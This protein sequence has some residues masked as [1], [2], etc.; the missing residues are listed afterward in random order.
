[1]GGE[2]FR[3]T[4]MILKEKLF[5][6][7][8]PYLKWLREQKGLS[9]TTIL[10][11]NRHYKSFVQLDLS[12]EVIDAFL[13]KQKNNSVVRGFMR[14]FLEFL[15]V[16]D[17]FKIPKSSTGKKK[18]RIIRN[19]SREQIRKVREYSYNKSLKDGLIIDLL[20]FGALRL[21]EI[22]TIKVNSF[23]WDTF[24]DDPTK[25]CKLLI[26]GKGKKQREVLINHGTLKKLLDYYLKTKVINVSMNKDDLVGVLSSNN[27]H[28]FKDLYERKIWGIIKRNAEKS[29]GIAM[30]P[31]ELRHTR[32]TE[33][34]K[35][36]ASIRSVQH[37]LGH[38]SP[39]ITEIYLHTTQT[40]SLQKI[41]DLVN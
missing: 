36:G 35:S 4:K 19:F 15:K 34:E 23:D 20:Y 17:Q 27:S 13:Q 32:A 24:L 25:F 5:E 38:S 40:Q 31:H 10:L 16:E 37:Y 33:L 41:M 22:Q 7:E 26:V 29:I 21:M 18:K 2:K 9:K 14:S 12:Q 11:Y 8:D 39:Q 30:R 6:S 1:V 3:Q 28:L